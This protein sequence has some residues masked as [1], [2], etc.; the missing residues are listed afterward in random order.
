MSIATILTVLTSL[1]QLRK[2]EHWTR[3]QLEAHQAQAL[4][5]LREYVYE[6]SPF[7][8]R[9]HRG[10]MD[11]PL[12][13]LPILTKTV[14]MEQFDDLVTDR[15]ICLVLQPRIRGQK[16]SSGDGNGNVSPDLDVVAATW[17]NAR[18][19]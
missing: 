14:M 13:E 12:S 9:F 5:Q 4:S 18:W 6:H 2:R 11:R 19:R 3:G 8:Q 7:Y 1:R 16:D 15:A 10:V 17:T